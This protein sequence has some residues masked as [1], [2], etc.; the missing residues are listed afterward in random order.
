MQENTVTGFEVLENQAVFSVIVNGRL[1]AIE[2]NVSD[3][4]AGTPL[5]QTEEFTVDGDIIT[6]A[7]VTLN[8]SEVEIITPQERIEEFQRRIQR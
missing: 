3:I 5:S 2:T 6:V 1:T 8:T 4:P 7:G